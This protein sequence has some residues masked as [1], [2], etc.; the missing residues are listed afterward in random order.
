MYDDTN[1]A[2]KIQSLLTPMIKQIIKNETSNCVKRKIMTITSLPSNNKV[3][4]SE[5]Y[6]NEIKLPY[7]STLTFSIGDNVIIEW[8]H[9]LNNA[10][11]VGKV[12]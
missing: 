10:I 7:A 12:V 5:A 6:G 4:V 3:G 1:E 11:V 8:F 2:L 9:S